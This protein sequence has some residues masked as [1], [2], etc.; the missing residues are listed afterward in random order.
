M[1]VSERF[2]TWLTALVVTLGVIAAA[3]MS[4]YSFL[5]STAPPSLH[6]KPEAAPSVKAATP[7]PRLLPSNSPSGAA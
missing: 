4:L 7:S 3:G 6:P 1:L 5:T 2:Q